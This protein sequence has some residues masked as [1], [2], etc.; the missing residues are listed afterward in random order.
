MLNQDQIEAMAMSDSLKDGAYTVTRETQKNGKQIW[1]INIWKFRSAKQVISWI[2][3]D[4]KQ[5]KK[6]GG[7]K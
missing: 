4:I 5:Q 7:S 2:K 1:A 6:F 3:W